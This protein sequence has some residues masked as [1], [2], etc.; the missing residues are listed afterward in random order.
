M[1]ADI[2]ARPNVLCCRLKQ[3]VTL[4]LD[5]ADRGLDQIF[6]RD[7][8]IEHRAARQ[9]RRLSDL[10]IVG[11]MVADLG[12]QGHGGIKDARAGSQGLGRVLCWTD[13]LSAFAHLP[14]HCLIHRPS[15]DAT[16]PL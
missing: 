2:F 11:G 3:G 4:G 10:G 15:Q 7:K 1:L 16:T 13:G 9:V 14:F 8:M 12:K 5:V 6:A